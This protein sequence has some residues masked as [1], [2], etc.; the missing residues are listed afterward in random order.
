MELK[1]E[2]IGIE[3]TANKVKELLREEKGISPSLRAMIELLLTI[4]KSLVDKL[5]LNSRNS[6]KPPSSDPN[7]KRPKKV[8]GKKTPGGQEGHNGTTLQKVG[9]PDEIVSLA[10]DKRTIP[11]GE[12]KD[13]GYE[14]RQVIDI[15]ISR[16]VIE[17]RAQILENKNG[18]RFTAAFPDNVNRPVQ[19]GVRLKA[20][21]VDMSQYQL[22][23]YNRIE[24]HFKNQVKIGISAGSIF[25]FNMEAFILLEQFDK[26]AKV[27]LLLSSVL[28]ADET[29]INVNGDN[30]WLHS[31]SSSLW[32]YFYPHKKRGSEAMDEIG[33]LPKY[34]GIL[35][36]DHWKA[37]YK[38]DKCLHS[39]C[40]SH[41]L[42][43]LERAWEQDNQMWAKEMKSLLE[44]M[45]VV[46][47]GNGGVLLPDK[48]EEYKKKYRAVLER[49]KKECPM[50]EKPPNHRGK[51]KK[52]KSRNLLER[53]SEY[54]DDTLRFM[55][56]PEVPFTNN[57]SENDIRMT[58]V[59]QKISGCFRSVEGAKIF[60]RVR[61]YISTCKKNGVGSVEALTLLFKG[62][63]PNFIK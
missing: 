9:D 31:A 25:N 7:R 44:E 26:I 28:H 15:K 39:L 22:I 46:V 3:D 55:E 19:Y 11:H 24:E 49:G 63:L 21:A 6:S 13:V 43:E 27:R 37:Y 16:H 1:L 14:S 8:K 29:G 23:P 57:R 35:C 50:P 58:K 59:Q 62:E 30:Y 32:T 5:T 41:H 52:T 51:L 2:N 12:Y 42:R 20:H 56:N 10:I 4:V 48:A 38:Y 40:N 33:I 61:S 60:C 47:N 53:L 17:Y 54:M 34:E 45:N 36:H 18:R